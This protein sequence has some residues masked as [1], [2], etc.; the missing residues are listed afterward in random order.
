MSGNRVATNN[1]SYRI[2]TLVVHK[3][4]LTFQAVRT[5]CSAPL[6]SV[7]LKVDPQSAVGGIMNLNVSAPQRRNGVATILMKS[8]VERARLQGLQA[9]SLEARSA[10]VGITPSSLVNLYQKAG[11]RVTGPAPLGGFKMEQRLSPGSPASAPVQ[12]RTAPGGAHA[13]NNRVTWMP[14]ILRPRVLQ[15]AKA[16]GE[17]YATLTTTT[18]ATYDGEYNSMVGYHAE[19]DALEQHLTNPGNGTVSKIEI[20]SPCCKACHEVLTELRLIGKVVAKDGTGHRSAYKIPPTVLAAY[21]HEKGISTKNA[22]YYLI[23][24]R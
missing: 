5:G 24:L 21:A 22:E 15:R 8:A 7:Q 6:G 13:A 18:G 10:E 20:S 2:Q 4:M 3:S 9:L 19:L 16:Q 14:Q 1:G 12:L 23:N 17:C 11:F